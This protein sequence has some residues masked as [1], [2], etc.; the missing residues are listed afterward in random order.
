MPKIFISWNFHFIPK[1]KNMLHCFYTY[2][3]KIQNTPMYSYVRIHLN[4]LL[5]IVNV[6]MQKYAHACKGQI[7]PCLVA[8]L[9]SWN[10]NYWPL[11]VR[12]GQ[13]IL[14]LPMTLSMNFWPSDSF[15]SFRFWFSNF[16]C[17]DVGRIFCRRYFRNRFDWCTWARFWS[18]GRR[19]GSIG[20]Y[21]VR[22]M[23]KF[24]IYRFRK[25]FQRN[26]GFLVFAIFVS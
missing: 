20:L 2:L 7:R 6:F 5:Y 17:E 25:S 24:W 13:E 8:R 16:S 26:F 4:T 12:F 23:V 21:F 19:Q 18:C 3:K 22:F 15:I 10:Y 9:V 11:Q 1:Q 14:V